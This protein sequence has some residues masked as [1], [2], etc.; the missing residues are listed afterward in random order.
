MKKYF[1]SWKARIFFI[2]FVFFAVL[3]L[4]RFQ[5]FPSDYSTVVFT[6][7]GELVGARLANDG[8]W[9]F[10]PMDTVPYKL[11]KATLCF[12]DKHF[13]RHPGVNPVSISVR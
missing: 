4:L 6:E 3:C 5:L 1:R 10:P 8:Q 2:L 7:K 9:R 11:K 13:Y 12:E